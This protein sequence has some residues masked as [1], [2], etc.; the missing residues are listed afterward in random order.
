ME[1]KKVEPI[2]MGDTLDQFS[3]NY[4]VKY[5]QATEVG[6]AQELVQPVQKVINKRVSVAKRTVLNLR[7][8]PTV[9]SRVIT[10]LTNGAKLK[11]FPDFEHPEFCKVKTSDGKIGYCVKKYVK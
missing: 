6:D 9:E 5:D 4:S 3:E 1:K 11:M 7:M 2:K 8:K 10:T